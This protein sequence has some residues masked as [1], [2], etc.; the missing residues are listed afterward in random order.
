MI[1]TDISP[2]MIDQARSRRVYEEL[3]VANANEGLAC[4]ASG[5]VDL[6]VCMGAMELLDHSLVLSEFARVLKPRGQLWASFQWER[7]DEAGR[8]Q[9]SATKHQNVK[10]VTQSELV[11]ELE[12]AGFHGSMEAMEESSCAFLTPSPAQDGA[13]LPVPYLYVSVPLRDGRAT[14]R[15]QNL[16]RF[17]TD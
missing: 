9:P 4:V 16:R 1:G 12:T 10:G 11:A 8:V 17:R 7:L 2:G 15:L 3:I 6:V 13:L 14:S 5:S